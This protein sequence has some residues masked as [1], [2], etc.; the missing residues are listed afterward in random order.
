MIRA[1]EDLKQYHGCTLKK[2][3][4]NKYNSESAIYSIWIADKSGYIQTWQEIS[5]TSNT[6]RDIFDSLEYDKRY[7]V[8]DIVKGQM[9]MI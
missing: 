5:T 1:L 6:L 2:K 9:I 7:K 3:V 4:P 8:D